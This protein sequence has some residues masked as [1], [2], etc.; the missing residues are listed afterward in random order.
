VSADDLLDEDVDLDRSDLYFTAVAFHPK[1]EFILVGAC[2]RFMKFWNWNLKE[3][4]KRLDVDYHDDIITS[5]AFSDH[6]LNI[7]TSSE[8]WTAR[9]WDID[10]G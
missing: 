1:Q 5:I 8:D 10:V 6:G 4:I 2:K 3:E 7:V 9:V